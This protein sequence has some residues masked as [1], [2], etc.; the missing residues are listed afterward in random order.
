MPHVL[1]REAVDTGNVDLLLPL[2]DGGEF[3]GTTPTPS[4]SKLAL[5]AAPR[6][7]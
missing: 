3:S 5:K 2:S 7:R 4:A 6:A 1:D